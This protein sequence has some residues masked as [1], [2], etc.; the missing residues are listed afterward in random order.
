MLFRELCRKMESNLNRNRTTDEQAEPHAS[1]METGNTCRM[2][3][4]ICIW[5]SQKLFSFASKKPNVVKAS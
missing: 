4:E 1:R 5:K 3:N 2:S